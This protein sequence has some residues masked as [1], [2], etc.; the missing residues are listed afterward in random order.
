MKFSLL[1]CVSKKFTLLLFAITKSDVDRFQL[2]GGNVA[3]QICSKLVYSFHYTV[4]HMCSDN[5]CRRPPSPSGVHRP[6]EGGWRGS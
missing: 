2:F 6:L 4:K 1:H 3:E 5:V